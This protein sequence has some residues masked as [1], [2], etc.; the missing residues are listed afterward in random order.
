LVIG[1]WPFRESRKLSQGDIQDGTGLLRCYIS[2]AENG[3]TI[4]WL[5]TL[6]K[7]A[8]ALEVHLNQVDHFMV[9]ATL[10]G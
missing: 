5:V 6:E 9:E 3:R 10:V 8:L 4:P 1:C 2:R 7:M